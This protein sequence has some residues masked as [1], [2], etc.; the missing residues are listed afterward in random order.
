MADIQ[1]NWI[2]D[3]DKVR[4][5]MPRRTVQSY[6]CSEHRLSSGTGVGRGGQDQEWHGEWNAPAIK[7]TGKME[8]RG[9]EKTTGKDRDEEEG[10]EGKR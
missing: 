6:Y 8:T 9:E 10:E 3:S 4:K 5:Q 7:P 2:R 1:A